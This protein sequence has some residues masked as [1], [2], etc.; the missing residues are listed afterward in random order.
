MG[1]VLAVILALIVVMA[2]PTAYG[3]TCKARV[4]GYS[5]SGVVVWTLHL[6]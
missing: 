4:T 3:L 6:V 1:S 2:V 5:P